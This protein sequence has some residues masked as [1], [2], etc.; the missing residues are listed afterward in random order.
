MD[1]KR[2]VD[3]R[4]W[5]SLQDICGGFR[6]HDEGFGL[7][8]FEG[9]GMSAAQLKCVECEDWTCW[10]ARGSLLDLL[11]RDKLQAK[12][13]KWL[14]TTRCATQQRSRAGAN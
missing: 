12:S 9:R 6:R 11:E 10:E 1:A 4:Q 2:S 14:G 7:R 5:Q 8:G 3:A 13:K